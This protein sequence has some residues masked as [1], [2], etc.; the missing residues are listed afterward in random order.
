VIDLCSMALRHQIR[1]RA[2]WGSDTSFVSSDH[3][4]QKAIRKPPGVHQ[5]LESRRVDGEPR[6]RMSKPL[7]SKT[8]NRLDI[9]GF[10]NV[11]DEILVEVVPWQ[12]LAFALCAVLAGLG[13]ALGSPPLLWLLAAIAALAAIFPV[14]PFDLLYNHLIR[15]LRETGPLPRRNAPSRFACGVGA[16]WL[17]P[18][19]LAFQA[20][21]DPIGY[22]LGAALTGVAGLVAITDICIPS[23]IYRALFGRP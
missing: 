20:G 23:M 1:V 8:R 9:Q 7:A 22:V 6:G 3:L 13:T 16:V 18:T 11:P 17:V 14:H 12:R 5:V 19:A 2:G 10:D 4:L 21:A 15:Y